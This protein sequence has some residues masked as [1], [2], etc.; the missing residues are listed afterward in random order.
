[1][2]E[3]VNNEQELELLEAIKSQGNAPNVEMVK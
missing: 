2:A 1:M 3:M